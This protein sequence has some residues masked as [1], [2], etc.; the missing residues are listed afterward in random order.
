MHFGPFLAT[1]NS[2][3]TFMGGKLKKPVSKV[4]ENLFKNG[5]MALIFSMATKIIWVKSQANS[6]MHGAKYSEGFSS[7][8]HP[9]AMHSIFPIY[10]IRAS[11]GIFP[12]CLA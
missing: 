4:V 9:Y 7:K 1:N 11:L 10:V 6:N 5:G 3:N 2:K 8:K 12:M